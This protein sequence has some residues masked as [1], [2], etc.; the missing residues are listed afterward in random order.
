MASCLFYKE[1]IQEFQV[2]YQCKDDQDFPE[3]LLIN[4]PFSPMIS[5][6]D[7]KTN[8]NALINELQRCF[9]NLIKQDCEIIAIACNT[10]HTLLNHL[11]IPKHICLRIDDVIFQ[12]IEKEGLKKIA[13][14]CTDTTSSLAL[15]Q[16]RNNYYSLVENIDQKIISSIIDQ[17]LTGNTSAQLAQELCQYIKKLHS[18]QAFDGIVMG[19]TEFSL[20]VGQRT[21]GSVV[22]AVTINAGLVLSRNQ[23]MQQRL[24]SHNVPASFPSNSGVSPC[25]VF[26]PSL[27]TLPPGK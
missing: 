4:Y 20:L 12:S 16:S 17:V 24:I 27:C 15:Y 13:L 14:L 3:I 5:L 22:I 7:I 6:N 2:T 19:C 1:L 9:D 11:S 18:E 26:R 8:K 25:L 21:G 10:L 23:F